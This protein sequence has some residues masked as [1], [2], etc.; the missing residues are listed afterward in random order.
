MQFSKY[1]I[2]TL[3]LTI[4]YSASYGQTYF[5]SYKLPFPSAYYQEIENQHSATLQADLEK[6]LLQ[7]PKWKKLIA[8]K[9]MAVGLVD[10]KDMT[11]IRFASVNGNHMMYAASLPKIAVLLSAIQAIDEGCLEYSDKLKKD[12]RLMISKSN[13]AATTRVIEALGFDKIA[14]TMTQEQYKLYDINKGGGLWVGKKYAKAGLKKPD[15]L[16]KLSHAATVDQVLRYY[17]MMAY[18]KLVS[19]EW[20]E[21]ML[22]YMIDPEINHKFVKSLRKIDPRCDIYRKSGSWRTYHS[23]SALV[24]GNDGRRY[25]LVALIQDMR[26]GSICSKLVSKVESVLGISQPSKV[27]KHLYEQGPVLKPSVSQK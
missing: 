11:N 18:G 6:V 20:S 5:G 21:E 19:P 16:K 22:Q 25:I 14:E 9:K 7:N 23:D 3:F 12:L 10:I 15:P 2:S 24:F 1:I 13:N 26:G 17:T 27:D 8:K 4:L